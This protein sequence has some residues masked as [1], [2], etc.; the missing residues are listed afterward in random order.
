[1]MAH[2]SSLLFN[3]CLFLLLIAYVYLNISAYASVF[4]GHVC[5]FF[6]K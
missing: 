6:S 4:F 3:P 2:F 5:I 1:M